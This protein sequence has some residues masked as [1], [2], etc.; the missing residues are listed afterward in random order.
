MHNESIR[1]LIVP[2]WQGSPDDHWQTHWQNSLPNSTRVEQ[3]DW[4]KPAVKTGWAS[5]NARL[6]SMTRP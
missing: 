1:Y 4:L 6:P 5:C 2:C 3:A